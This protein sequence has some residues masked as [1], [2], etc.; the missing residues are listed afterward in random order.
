LSLSHEEFRRIGL[1]L[2]SGDGLRKDEAEFNEHAV[3]CIDCRNWLDEQ[4]S[5]DR[6]VVAALFGHEGDGLEPANTDVAIERLR[7]WDRARIG[8]NHGAPPPR[9]HWPRRLAVA[10]ATAAVL[11]CGILVQSYFR[12]RAERLAEW[13]EECR[14]GDVSSCNIIGMPDPLSSIGTNDEWR[15]LLADICGGGAG[16]CSEA[17]LAIE[18]QR[19]QSDAMLGYRMACTHGDTAAC[20]RVDA[21]FRQLVIGKGM[22]LYDLG[23]RQ[24][25]QT[26]TC[27]PFSAFCLRESDAM[28]SRLQREYCV[29]NADLAGCNAQKTKLP[30]DFGEVCEDTGAYPSVGQCQLSESARPPRQPIESHRVMAPVDE[31]SDRE[32]PGDCGPLGLTWCGDAFL[33]GASY[34]GMWTCT[35]VILNGRCQRLAVPYAFDD[36][37]QARA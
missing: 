3:R 6:D 33:N 14:K 23:G 16:R 35:P 36:P 32:C 29:F 20:A 26:G 7:E 31:L 30:C 8:G 4:T 2:L 24:S 19:T 34:A 10:I 11:V 9:L 37:R 12:S 25:C 21:I 5:L 15:M 28:D 18:Q 17:A 1:R 27:R 13:T 22:Q